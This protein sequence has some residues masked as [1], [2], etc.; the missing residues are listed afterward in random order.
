MPS[1]CFATNWAAELEDFFPPTAAAAAAGEGVK[2]AKKG[3]VNS[4]ESDRAPPL[5][6]EPGVQPRPASRCS[7]SA[8]STLA[9]MSPKNAKTLAQSPQSTPL[10][11]HVSKC[12]LPPSHV[13]LRMKK[14]EELK[15]VRSKDTICPSPRSQARLSTL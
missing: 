1:G 10:K 6:P 11:C 8:G 2:S 3:S 9:V 15:Q 13:T 14:S 12:Q 4:I 7:L 5:T